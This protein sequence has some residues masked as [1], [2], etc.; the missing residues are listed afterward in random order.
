MKYKTKSGV[1]VDLHDE[2][3][4]QIHDMYSKG[5]FDPDKLETYFKDMYKKAHMNLEMISEYTIDE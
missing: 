2:D 1:E 3:I 4:K 5:N